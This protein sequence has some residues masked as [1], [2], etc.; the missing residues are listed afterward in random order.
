MKD[1]I[2]DTIGS[3]LVSVRAPEGATVAAK[4]ESFNPGGPRRTGRRST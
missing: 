3:P 1:S 2:L 4:I